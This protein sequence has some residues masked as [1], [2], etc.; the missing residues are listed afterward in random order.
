MTDQIPTS[1]IKPFGLRLPP[2]LK[3]W[4]ADEARKNRRSQNAELIHRLEQMREQEQ[5]QA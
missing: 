5:P 2:A 4:I 1:H 3:A